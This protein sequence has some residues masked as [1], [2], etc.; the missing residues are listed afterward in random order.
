M[1]ALILGLSHL[2]D[3]RFK[4]AV[5]GYYRRLPMTPAGP[6]VDASWS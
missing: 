5:E 3:G 1:R 2:R 6:A 4:A